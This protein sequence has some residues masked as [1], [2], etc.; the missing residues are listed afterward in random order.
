M[1]IQVVNSSKFCLLISSVMP[2]LCF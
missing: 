2:G 1:E